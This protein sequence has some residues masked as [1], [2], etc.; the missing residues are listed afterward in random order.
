MT[1]KGDCQSMMDCNDAI[2]YAFRASTV[3]ALRVSAVVG[4]LPALINH[5]DDWFG[6]DHVR[7]NLIQ[8]GLSYLVSYLAAVHEQLY[9]FRSRQ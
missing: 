2:D 6:A 7:V 8:V 4:T 1:I 3:R 5:D 9:G